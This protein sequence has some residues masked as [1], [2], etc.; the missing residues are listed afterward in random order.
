MADITVAGAQRDDVLTRRAE[1][2]REG[3]VWSFPFLSR[4][5]V[6]L[7]LG[8]VLGTAAF[9]TLGSLRIGA[10][11]RIGRRMP[12]R[13]IWSRFLAYLADQGW[14]AALVVAVSAAAAV[15][16]ICAAIALWL[17]F[18]LRDEHPVPDADAST[19]MPPSEA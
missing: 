6:L 17:A 14:S 16:L 15:A 2:S 3:V 11:A 1:A 4:A 13:E 19:A 7:W 5:L 12:V 18:G 9:L 10:G 8:L